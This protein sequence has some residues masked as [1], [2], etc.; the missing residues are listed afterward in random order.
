MSALSN[1]WNTP[2][3]IPAPGIEEVVPADAGALASMLDRCKFDI[4]NPPPESP[5]VFLLKNSVIATRGNL[6]CVQAGPKAGKTAFIGA[7]VAA[8]MGAKGDCLGISSSNP[9]GLALIHFDCEQSPVDHHK[10]NR[11]ALARAE[12]DAP[13]SWFRSYCLTGVTLAQRQAALGLELQRASDECSGIHCVIL[14]GVADLVA[15]PNDST[16]AFQTI[17]DLHQKAIQHDTVIVCI[18]HENPGSEIGKTRGHLGSQLERKAESNLRLV[19][20]SNGVTVV[21]TER[22]RHTHI[23]KEQGPR[24]QW[25]PDAGMHVSTASRGEIKRD[26]KRERLNAEAMEVF[27]DAPGACLSWGDTHARIREVGG[28]K[29]GDRRRFNDMLKFGIIRKQGQNYELAPQ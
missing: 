1:H 26:E 6:V 2:P 18:L 25:C 29:S 23:T 4:N 27:K 16:E 8:A 10:C 21:Y 12:C 22:A 3:Q 13:T 19:K 20:D 11:R 17:D 5:P 14:D 15:D 9:Q 24:F 7:M 28:L